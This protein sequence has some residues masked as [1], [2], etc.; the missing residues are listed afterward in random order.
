MLMISLSRKFQCSLLLISLLAIFPSIHIAQIMPVP[1]P[2]PGELILSPYGKLVVFVM[3]GLSYRHVLPHGLSA[4]GEIGKWLEQN[5]SMALLNTMGYGGN[6]RFRSAMTIACGV[7]AFADESAA[8]VL[9]AN[10]PFDADIAWN[11]YKRRVGNLLLP[12]AFKPFETLVFPMIV[13]LNWQN[14]RLQKKSVPFGIV[15]QSLSQHGIRIIGIGCGDLPA[16][17]SQQSPLSLFRHGLLF[18]LDEKGL[19]IGLTERKLLRKDPMMPYGLAID[20]NLWQEKVFRAWQVAN[21]IVL[22]PGETFRADLY[23]SERLIS[24]AIRR[25]LSLLSPVVER[26]NLKRDLLVVFS[27]APSQRNR[28]E[29]SF[30]CAVGKGIDQNG[31]LTSLTTHQVGLVSI[32]DIPATILDFFGLEPLQPINGSPI[33]SL[34]KSLDKVKL[35]QMGAKAQATDTYIRTIILVLWCILQVIVFGSIAFFALQRNLSA[36]LLNEVIVLLIF[37]TAG[38]HLITGLM[39]LTALL[40]A[41]AVAIFFGAAKA[42]EKGLNKVLAMAIIFAAA[43]FIADATRLLP[44]SVDSPFGYSTFFGGRY[45]GQ[46]NVSMGLTLGAIFAL[47]IALNWQRWATAGSIFVGSILVGAPFFGANI[48][49]ALTGFI[50]ALTSLLAGRIRSWHLLTA[51]LA[52]VVFLLGLAAFE[53]FR[54]EPLTHW[55]RFVYAFAEEG[56]GAITSMV[57]MKL[58]ISLRAFRAVYW[59][60]ALLAQGILI[61]ILWQ[62]NGK[63]WRFTTLSIGAIAA[64]L[65][66]DSGPQ[67]PVAFMFFPLCS[68]YQKRRL[69]FEKSRRDK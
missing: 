33:K 31:L 8:F 4:F 30:L 46:G 27:L 17:Q 48:G 66:N 58:G 39:P 47:S 29:L 21:V 34:P 44:L 32:L 37:L 35:W 16:I 24:A 61:A 65:L 62:M 54:Q 57:W 69:C 52:I 12:H 41:I 19:G 36:A 18:A 50:T 14:E 67:T 13:E 40:T 5:G 15:A 64:L 22:F 6:D 25:E 11:A 60:M 55:G 51:V 68:L 9:Q 28:Y 45:Y 53:L 3:D 10:E 42:K 43:V 1:L 26:I 23:G 49:G 59:D 56:F 7:R 63:D 38:L 2:P 20:E